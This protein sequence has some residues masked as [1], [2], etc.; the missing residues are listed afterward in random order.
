M[1]PNPITLAQVGTAFLGPIPEPP[2]LFTLEQACRVVA[3]HTGL[4]YE[5]LVLLAGSRRRID[6]LNYFRRY[7]PDYS[8]TTINGSGQKLLAA[9]EKIDALLIRGAIVAEE[10]RRDEAQEKER[11]ANRKLAEAANV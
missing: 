5:A 4:S 10:R 9:M 11:Q 8:W 2:A 3:G 7:Y 1:P 6:G